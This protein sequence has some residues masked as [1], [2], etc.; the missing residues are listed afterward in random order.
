MTE[1]RLRGIVAEAATRVIRESGF[2]SDKKMNIYSELD[3]F[4]RNNGGQM[5]L[6]DVA[7]HFT[8]YGYWYAV[9][10]VCEWL[11][12]NLHLVRDWSGTPAQNYRE[13]V[14]MLRREM[15]LP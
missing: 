8:K 5:T 14:R 10:N 2:D 1:G 11:T 4:A 9:E 7:K 12:Y 6:A 13:L 3:N 15:Q